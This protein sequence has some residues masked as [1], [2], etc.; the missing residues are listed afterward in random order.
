MTHSSQPTT[1]TSPGFP[2]YGP[3]WQG[4][5]LHQGGYGKSKMYPP[6][7]IPGQGLSSQ[8]ALKVPRGPPGNNPINWPPTSSP[9]PPPPGPSSGE[10][11]RLCI[12]LAM[13]S[14]QPQL[15][16]QTI[17]VAGIVELPQLSKIAY[18]EC[19]GHDK[20]NDFSDLDSTGWKPPHSAR[21]Q[22]K[23]PWSN[24]PNGWG[25]P[26]IVL[27]T[28]GREYGLLGLLRRSLG[29]WSWGRTTLNSFAIDPCTGTLQW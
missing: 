10:S 6:P 23:F 29:P 16:L 19:D 20:S 26:T 25:R 28:S 1:S 7:Q 17:D 27:S 4:Y 18:Y 2:S 13:K 12:S 22:L 24:L 21:S 9:T 14:F 11:G 3:K 15:E 5:D 8:G